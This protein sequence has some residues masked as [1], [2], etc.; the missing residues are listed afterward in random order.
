MNRDQ[1]GN[2][3]NKKIGSL[4]MGLTDHSE[5]GIHFQHDN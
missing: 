4:T 1:R 3:L 2:E 5:M